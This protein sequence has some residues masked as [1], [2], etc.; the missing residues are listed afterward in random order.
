MP[1]CLFIKTPNNIRS[2]KVGRNEILQNSNSLQD[3]RHAAAHFETI[4]LDRLC[5]SREQPY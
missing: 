1:I 5:T 4:N 3:L 2:Y